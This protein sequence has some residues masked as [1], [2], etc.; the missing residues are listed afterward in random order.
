MGERIFTAREKQKCA[1]RE[2]GQRQRTY[3][4]LVAKRG[5]DQAKADHQIALM[6]EIEADYRK[7]ADA[8]ELA[9]GLF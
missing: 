3:A 5:M 7:I 6:Q 2:V 4:H 1:A 9:G 8:E